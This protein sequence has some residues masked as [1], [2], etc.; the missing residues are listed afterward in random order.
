MKRIP[1]VIIGYCLLAACYSPLVAADQTL[2]NTKVLIHGTKLSSDSSSFGLAGW[3]ILPNPGNGV[4]VT[5][6]GPR[7]SAESGSIE[8]MFGV[9]SVKQVGEPF[10]DLRASYD[11]CTPFHYW[12]NI[13]YF[14]KSGNWY[15]YLDANLDLGTLVKVGV[16]SENTLNASAPDDLSIGPRIVI[17]FTKQFSMVGAYQFHS[18]G[19]PCQTWARAVVNF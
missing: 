19:N 10:I 14:P 18:Q 1:T 11:A 7:Y 9:K 12:T 13:E 17:P 3:F 2:N 4:V 5:I 6:A 8:V 15:L 16:E